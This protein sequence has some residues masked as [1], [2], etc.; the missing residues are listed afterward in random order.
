MKKFNEVYFRLFFESTGNI[1]FTINGFKKFL[2]T[3]IKFKNGNIINEDKHLLIDIP[4]EFFN[5]C[6][7]N[8]GHK[9]SFNKKF[10]V[11]DLLEGKYLGYNKDDQAILHE[12]NINNLMIK[13]VN[14]NIAN[15]YSSSSSER[16]SACFC[17]D[18]K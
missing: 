9:I 5:Y 3:A 14:S 2:D 15:N 13:N 10:Y 18:V 17:R 1:S 8:Q 4:S 11:F 16:N 6:I 7:E 12:T